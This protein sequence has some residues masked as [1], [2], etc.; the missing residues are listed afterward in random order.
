MRFSIEK[1]IGAGFALAVLCL[2]LVGVVSFQS[3]LQLSRDAEKTQH[4][5]TALTQLGALRSVVQ[6]DEIGVHAYL[7][8]GGE[9]LLE[10]YRRA[11][12]DY[13]GIERWLRRLTRDNPDQ[14]QRFERLSERIGE[15]L[16]VS[17]AMVELMRTRGFET[18]RAFE[19]TSKRKQGLE[20]IRREI[21]K[22]A[23]SEQALLERRTSQTRSS[24][25]ATL[26]AIVLSTLLAFAL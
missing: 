9:T 3:T 11:R 21:S 1:T 16:L 6:D 24:T 15:H 22:M 19:E 8:G 17:Q 25:S 2:T 12:A 7:I 20:V 26:G 23:N 4:S 14:K 5:Q 18:A 13:P 10:P